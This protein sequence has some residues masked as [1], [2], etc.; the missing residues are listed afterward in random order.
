MLGREASKGFPT[1]CPEG[2]LETCSA[3]QD[4]KH[5]QGRDFMAHTTPEEKESRRDE[6]RSPTDGIVNKEGQG[7]E[8]DTGPERHQEDEQGSWENKGESPREQ[9]KNPAPL[10][11]K[12]T[13]KQPSHVPGGAWLHKVRAYWK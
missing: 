4:S 6:A 5:F 9:M 13:T 2:T 8:R 3:S 7:G 12:N 1:K 11:A 10:Q